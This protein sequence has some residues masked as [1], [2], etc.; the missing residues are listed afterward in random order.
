MWLKTQNVYSLAENEEFG[1]SLME[2]RGCSAKRG[3]VTCIKRREPES[4][5]G[6]FYDSVARSSYLEE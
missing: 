6:M 2:T 1:K 5:E 3:Y 4:A